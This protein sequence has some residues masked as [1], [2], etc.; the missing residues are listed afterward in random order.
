MVFKRLLGKGGGV[1]SNPLL[2]DTVIPDE[3][4]Q[5]GGLLRGEI[6]LRAPDR[7]VAVRHIDVKLAANTS[8]ALGKDAAVDTDS[9]DSFAHFRVTS[10]FTVKKGE[11][12][13]VP[14]RWRLRWESPVSEVR[15]RPLDGMRF[16]L[17]TEVEADGIEDR[18]DGDPLRIAATPLHEAVLDAFAAAG[19][20][21]R[22]AQIDDGRTIPR[23]ERHIYM[24]QSFRL[25]DTQ[26]VNDTTG[27]P[28]NLEVNFHT[29]AVGCEIFVRKAALSQKF[30]SEK[31]PYERYVAAHHEVGRV[32]FEAAVRR[33]IEEVTALPEEREDHRVERVQYDL[34][35][36]REW[37][38][39]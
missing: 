21:H 2:I 20:S 5:P 9:G 3:P 13:R 35:S 27:R 33:W 38:D 30:W 34:G 1:P 16:A 18:T 14:L 19:Y 25:V 32:D 7:D 28:L 39:T 8:L 17:Y 12:T 10:L 31:P 4:L 26:A 37:T 6:V 11:E 15:G 36:P 23:T 22:S 24:R 29:N